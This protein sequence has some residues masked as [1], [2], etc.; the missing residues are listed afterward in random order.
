VGGL[1]AHLLL[2]VVA[3]Q[4]ILLVCISSH[5]QQT[6]SLPKTMRTFVS[7]PSSEGTSATISEDLLA[8]LK[9]SGNKVSLKMEKDLVKTF[10]RNEVFPKAKFLQPED[11]LVSGFISKLIRK[12]LGYKKGQWIEVWDTWAK[13]L[14]VKTLNE[15]RNCVAQAI[16]KEET[17]REYG[18]RKKEHC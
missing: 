3:L 15:K 13:A 11:L 10:V 5:P 12:S 7:P 2:L 14:T 18:S 8:A 1:L 16:A 17:K 9:A 4:K 6:S